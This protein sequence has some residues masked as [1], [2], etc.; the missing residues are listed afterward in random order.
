MLSSANIS[1]TVNKCYFV[2]IGGV[3]EGGLKGAMLNEATFNY[4]NHYNIFHSIFSR[5]FL[6]LSFIIPFIQYLP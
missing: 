1:I 5:Y 2:Y 4:I 3:R 6:H